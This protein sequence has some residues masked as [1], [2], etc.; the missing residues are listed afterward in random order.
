MDQ[1]ASL[2]RTSELLGVDTQNMLQTVHDVPDQ[3]VSGWSSMAQVTLPTH[4]VQATGVY[5]LG[6]GASALAGAYVKRL[7]AEASSVPIDHGGSATLPA[8]VNGR[9]LVVAVSYSGQTP[10]IVRGFA[11]AAERGCKLFAITT[12]GEL[13]A[14]CRKHR[15]PWYQIQYGAL[16][17]AAFGYLFAPLLE[18][19]TR[20]GF[21]DKKALKFEQSAAALY[22]YAARLDPALPVNQNPA[23][24]L[25]TKLSGRQLFLVASDRCQPVADRWVAQLAQNAKYLAWSEPIQTVQHATVER[26]GA[27]G[28]PQSG[29][30][31]VNF[32][33]NH[34]TQ[35]DA[36]ALNG[37][38]QLLS[39]A[40][41]PGEELLLDGDG[42]LLQELLI[43]TLLGD[44]V[45]V[46]L[47]LLARTDPSPT[48]Q[49]DELT[50]RL[51]GG[52][53]YDRRR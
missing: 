4:Y 51:G 50:E 31:T 34:D 12:G 48:P 40:K 33:S 26:F 17:R 19:L 41:L 23:K 22:D 44:Y 30:Y 29:I 8:Y 11:E 36:L 39:L 37:I 1:A 15:A 47:A 21:L 25:A 10:E 14:L 20:L 7:G 5:I 27:F 3:I 28:G 38:E 49:L 35:A 2:E 42:T 6:R 18:A 43:Y 46:Y 9:T 45:S 52:R 32:R 24:T 13:G 16:P 53:I